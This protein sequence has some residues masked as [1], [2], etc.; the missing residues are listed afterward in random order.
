MFRSWLNVHD[1]KWWARS[2]LEWKG[3]VRSD[4]TIPEL[5]RTREESY[6]YHVQTAGNPAKNQN[7]YLINK[8]KISCM[9]QLV[10][11]IM[12]SIVYIYIYICYQDVDRIWRCSCCEHEEQLPCSLKAGSV[13]GNCTTELLCRPVEPQWGGGGGGGRQKI[14]HTKA[15]LGVKKNGC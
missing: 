2:E 3:F 5:T 8:Q 12:K 1:E 7:K 14:Y 9:Y 10:G 13:E 11:K 6:E 4:C 15:R